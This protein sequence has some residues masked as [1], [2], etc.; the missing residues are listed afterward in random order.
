MK[1][2]N[3]LV[4]EQTCF[5]ALVVFV[6]LAATTVA[7]AGRPVLAQ[8]TEGDKE[9]LV[10]DRVL[11]NVRKATGIDALR[12]HPTGLQMIGKGQYVGNA[13]RVTST[14]DAQGRFV[15]RMDGPV[16]YAIGFDGSVAWQLEFAGFPRQLE[17]GEKLDEQ[18]SGAAISRSWLLGMPKLQFALSDKQESNDIISLDFKVE[19]GFQTGT[20]RIDRKTWLPTEFTFGGGGSGHRRFVYEGVREHGGMKWPARIREGIDESA[21][22]DLAI[23]TVSAA[24]VFVRSPC[25]MPPEPTE[26][27]RFDGRVAAHL[28]VERA[29]TGHLL[30]QPKINGK[31]R[32]WFIFD[33][34]A[35][36]TCFSQ[37]LAIE[38]KLE[39]VGAVQALGVGGS[40]TS[41]LFRLHSIE[42]G[43]LT[44]ER[45]IVMG[46]DLSFLTKPLGRPIAGIVGYDVL[47]RCVVELGLGEGRVA[48]HDPATFKRAGDWAT[49]HLPARVPAVD[50]NIEGHAGILRLDSGFSGK[51]LAIHYP[52]VQQF[53]MLEGRETKPSR[54]GGVGG[55]VST[56]A[57]LLK[58][59]EFAGNRVESVE[60]V[61]V[62]EPKGAFASPYTFGVMGGPLMRQFRIVIDYPGSRIAFRPIPAN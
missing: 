20:I 49:L 55:T 27:V 8:T 32:G 48:L 59:I 19:T 58:W 14:F 13:V 41:P 2:P 29:P 18:L 17:L 12:N 3:E 7:H 43:P 47:A 1:W 4:I 26:R 60:T 31:E 24:P 15:R 16:D 21:D 40:V 51:G 44:F 30:V 36:I 37:S 34:G 52:A 45:D 42:L 28:V 10:L 33:T 57:G 22:G 39:Q 6:A 38:M 50:A 35:G 46:L 25:A 53:K 62:L 5:R 23:E 9:P 54:D 61:F 11:E 56:A